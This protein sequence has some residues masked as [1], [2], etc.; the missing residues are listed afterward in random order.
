[1]CTNS[2]RLSAQASER[3]ERQGSHVGP[4]VDLRGPSIEAVFVRCRITTPGKLTPW[5]GN[6]IRGMVLQPLRDSFC[7]LS[8]EE[9]AG[10]SST[11]SNQDE[12]YCTGCLR[13][14]ECLYGRVY[15]PDRQIID[16]TVRNGMRQGLRGI[17]T[18]TEFP[19]RELATPG[20]EIVI[21]LLAIGEASRQLVRPT[22]EALAH[23]GRTSGLGPDQVRLALGHED[24]STHT[25]QLIADDL[26]TSLTSGKV[27]WLQINLETPLYLKNRSRGR[28]P[29]HAACPTLG[30]LLRES[31]RTVRRALSEFASPA[32]ELDFDPRELFSACDTLSSEQEAFTVFHQ[33]RT[34]ARQ[35][36]RWETSGWTGWAV[37][38]DVPLSVLPWLVWG[39]RLG[40]G[41]SRNCGAGLWHMAL[42]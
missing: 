19:L 36:S 26:P 22:L 38:R 3:I 42:P 16:G 34:S 27:P 40:V 18:S 17:T 6:A 28:Q 10:R 39:G 20:D 11:S 14:A 25:W 30:M 13:N 29:R 21:R 31:I 8:P 23:Q 41:D 24:L 37:Y 32:I 7:L 2:S 33:S 9:R 35:N 4:Q 15:E 12:R 5:L 1:M